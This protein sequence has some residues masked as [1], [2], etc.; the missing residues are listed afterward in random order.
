MLAFLL[1]ARARCV[2]FQNITQQLDHFDS[3]SSC[4]FTQRYFIFYPER[5]SSNFT[6]LYL[7][8]DPSASPPENGTVAQ[9]A[10]LANA[11]VYSLEHRFTGNSFPELPLTPENLRFMS[12]R[13][14]LEDISAFIGSV[15]H[16]SN[17]LTKVIVVGGS[18]FGSPASW[19]RLTYPSLCVPA[20]AS[21]AP[22][23]VFVEFPQFDSQ[24]QKNIPSDCATRLKHGYNWL[25]GAFRTDL[26]PDIWE[27]LE[28]PSDTDPSSALFVPADAV[29]R[30]VEAD[31]FS[32]IANTT[33]LKMEFNDVASFGRVLNE[34]LKRIDR[35][36]VSLDPLKWNSTQYNAK[37]ASDRAWM[38]LKC[39]ELGWFQTSGGFR[40]ESINRSY[41][42]R[43]CWTLFGQTVGNVEST[44]LWF[45]GCG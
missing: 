16:G 30:A 28:L 3:H 31:L 1:S 32:D 43:V 33:C 45:G 25:E 41:L 21:S 19:F 13:Q 15:I 2:D 17:P 26:S 22:V 9:L 23:Q 36:A 20:W 4:N 40:P 44:N 34:T 27:A 7:G 8:P 42:E 29:A 12:V 11:A 39:T 18:Y 24:I 35:T 5:K 10:T 38:W 6:I 37:T 14:A